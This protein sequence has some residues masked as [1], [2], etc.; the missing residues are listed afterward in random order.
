MKRVEHRAIYKIVQLSRE[1][2][3]HNFPPTIA[4][5][6]TTSTPQVMKFKARNQE[7]VLV[8]KTTDPNVL[9]KNSFIGKNLI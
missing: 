7:K 8:S 5:L 2:S 9:G 3:K 4:S 6:K 1:F